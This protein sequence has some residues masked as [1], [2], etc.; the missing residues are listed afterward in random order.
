M[1]KTLLISIALIAL[2][3]AC[4]RKAF[5][6]KLTGT[7]ELNKYLFSGQNNT[8]YYDT[9]FRQWKLTLTENQ[10]YTKTWLSYSYTPQSAI[11]VDTISYDSVGMVYILE[12]DTF[13]YTDT[14][15]TPR[16]EI[17]KWELINSEE[18]LQL[19]NDSTR[20]VDIYRILDLTQKELNLRK[21]NE[22]LYLEK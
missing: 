20:A 8:M 5:V 22:E 9:T 15:I 11:L 19:R 12:F 21:G 14:T 3:A 1:K 7:W 2:L 10:V 6:K 4:N 17:G 16:I 13:R 18:D